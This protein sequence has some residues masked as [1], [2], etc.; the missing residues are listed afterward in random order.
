MNCIL[1]FE[2]D[3]KVT[4]FSVQ[5]FS[6]SLFTFIFLV[7]ASIIDDQQKYFIYFGAMAVTGFCALGSMLFFPFRQK[8]IESDSL[9][10]PSSD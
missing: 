3:S 5:K 4:P 1:A 9:K 7:I 8:S 2:Y 6:Q 10:K